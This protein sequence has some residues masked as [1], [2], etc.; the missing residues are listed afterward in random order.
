M[1]DL[2]SFKPGWRLRV[3][4]RDTPADRIIWTGRVIQYVPDE[5]ALYFAPDNRDYVSWFHQSDV[6]E[7]RVLVEVLDRSEE[8]DVEQ[9]DR[10]WRGL[11]TKDVLG[12]T[13]T[14]LTHDDPVQSGPVNSVMS[15][16]K[17]GYD[18]PEVAGKVWVDV[19]LLQELV[20][21]DDCWYDHHGYCQAHNLH[22][23]PCPHEQAKQILRE[24][25]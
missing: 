17:G 4:Y 20:D 11:A 6:D 18:D 23:A 14:T 12:Q 3:R 15:H 25:T 10:P 13:V 19:Q 1:T 16:P 21:P 8:V 2:M 24:Q 9:V 5:S 22:E 7:G